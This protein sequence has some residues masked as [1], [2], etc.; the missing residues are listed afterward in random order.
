MTGINRRK[1]LVTGAAAATGI[2]TGA[3]TT[4][5]APTSLGG[6][7]VLTNAAVNYL[8]EFEI[9]HVTV[10]QS[11]AFDNAN[12]HIYIIQVFNSAAGDMVLTKLD[13]SRNELGHMH[14]KGFGHGVGMG[15]EPDGSTAWIWTETD[16]NPASGYG[17]AITRFPFQN[18]QTLTYGTSDIP[19]WYPVPGST[20]NH[21]NVDMLNNRLAVR[22]RVSGNARYAIFDLDEAK[23]GRFDPLYEFPELAVEPGVPFQGF[24][25]HGDYLYQMTG[26]AYTDENGD[27][28]PSKRGNVWLSAIDIRTGELDQHVWTQAAYSLDF[29]EPEGLGVQLTNPPRLHLGFA[30]GPVGARLATLYYKPQ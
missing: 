11:F 27:N 19:V 29:R 30:S 16:S 17:R 15:V 18:G 23:Q 9:H 6:R 4:A 3:A 8:R 2:L 7:F 21:P 28:P 1:L 22:H 25:L 10:L 24:C 12:N 14:L 13:H 20:S 5:P 26:N